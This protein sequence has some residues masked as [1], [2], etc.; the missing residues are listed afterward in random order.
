MPN[1]G[2]NPDNLDRPFRLEY[3]SQFAREWRFWG[4][5]PTKPGAERAWEDAARVIQKGSRLR[6]VCDVIIKEGVG[7]PYGKAS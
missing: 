2:K 3:Y 4:R 7:R 6:I 1:P 5:Y